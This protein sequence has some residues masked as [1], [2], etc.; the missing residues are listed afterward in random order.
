MR[1]ELD[2]DEYYEAENEFE[3]LDAVYHEMDSITACLLEGEYE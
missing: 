2:M 3:Y 1:L